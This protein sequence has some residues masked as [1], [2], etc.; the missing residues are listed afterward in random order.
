M[1]RIAL[2]LVCGWMALV[3]QAREWRP[4]PEFLRAV[5]FVES[6]NGANKVGDNGESLGDFQLS[7]A[8]WLDVNA[9]RRARSLKTYPY[10]NAVFH[11]YITRVYASNYLTILYTELN[12]RLKRPPSHG[13]LYAAYNLGLSS[14]AQCDFQLHRVNP[15]TR[16]RCEQIGLLLAEKDSL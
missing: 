10:E 7:E 16:A 14:F 6:S 13:E 5:R 11:S 9:W 2:L 3:T 8:A 4:T 1:N 15:L 12:R